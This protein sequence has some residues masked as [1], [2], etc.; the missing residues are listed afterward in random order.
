[1][2]QIFSHDELALITEAAQE[3]DMTP[4]DWVRG[5]VLQQFTDDPLEET[6]RSPHA[7]ADLRGAYRPS[8]EDALWPVTTHRRSGRELHEVHHAGCWVPKSGGGE[9]TTVTMT[10]AQARAELLASNA[11][12]C[13]ACQPERFLTPSA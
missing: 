6:H 13:D 3:A 10:T 11:R 8:I 4:R 5:V 7:P 9:E 1:M 12:P 2:D